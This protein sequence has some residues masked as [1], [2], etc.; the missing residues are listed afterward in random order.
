MADPHKDNLS[1][2]VSKNFHIFWQFGSGK[3][4]KMDFVKKIFCFFNF[5]FFYGFYYLLFIFKILRKKKKTL[6]I[7]FCFFKKKFEIYF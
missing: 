4:Q 5:F 7:N 1:N 6:T 3:C 2:L